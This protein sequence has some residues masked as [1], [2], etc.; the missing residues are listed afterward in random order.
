MSKLIIV[1]HHE[2]EWNALGKWTGWT[3][4]PLTER[5]ALLSHD[6]GLLFKDIHVDQAF[7]STQIRAH[8]TYYE[9][10]NAL[11]EYDV[12]TEESV[13][14]NER[15]YGEYTGKNKWEMKELLGEEQF[16]RIR[17]DWD[18][19]VPGGET[20]KMVYERAVPF[21]ISTIVPEVRS[22]K[23]VLVVSHG[24]AIRALMKYIE[25]IPDEEVKHIEMLLGTVVV[26]EV[27]TEGHMLSKETR[28]EAV[29]S[30]A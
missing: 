2:S 16:D 11:A 23:N 10:M 13:T 15:N 27:D 14:L 20:L 1:R 7:I 3:D 5:G 12:P 8:E 17:R 18:C 29:K 21:Y 26:Y 4:V 22:G 19:H 24:N 9:M 28:G 6:M 25:R 30:N